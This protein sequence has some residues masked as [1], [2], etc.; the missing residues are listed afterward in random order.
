MSHAKSPAA[1]I[2]ADEP[3]AGEPK[4]ERK[5]K[6]GESATRQYIDALLE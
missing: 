3:K 4:P 1:S 6:K 2:A 5:K